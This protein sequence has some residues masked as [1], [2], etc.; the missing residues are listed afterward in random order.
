MKKEAAELEEECE[1]VATARSDAEAQAHE[2]VPAAIDAVALVVRA[3]LARR[4][5]GRDQDNGHNSSQRRSSRGGF[6]G[7]S[8]WNG[9]RECHSLDRILKQCMDCS[10]KGVEDRACA[11]WVHESPGRDEALVVL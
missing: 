6:D 9:V 3:S 4:A 1:A 8:R 7:G 2:S 11:N 10:G 5:M